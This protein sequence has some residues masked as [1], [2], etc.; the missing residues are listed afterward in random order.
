MED[1]IKPSLDQIA[2]KY[3]TDKG[4]SYRGASRH[5]YAPFYD[6]ILS[7]W[8]ND[9]IRMLEIGICME[10]TE[11][12]HSV[13]MWNEYFDNASIFTF[14]IVDMSDHPCIKKNNNV[15]FYKGDQS[16]RNDFISMYENFGSLDFDFILEDG[17]HE[18]EH[19]MISIG[20]LFKY[21]K[22]GGYYILEDVSIPGNDVCCIRNDE[23]YEIIHN[24][25][26]TG[27]FNSIHITESEKKYL[28]KNIK[29]VDIH[30]DVQDAYVTVIFE[31]NK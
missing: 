19:Q 23:T 31:K 24:F 16:D 14:D 26:K 11:G 2:N 9:K 8:R 25:I 5:G 30:T 1:L 17:S 6:S 12:G 27:K 4:T 7:K 20:H 13:Y 3:N 15:F 21:V 10:R 22:P 18:H 29:S 28:E